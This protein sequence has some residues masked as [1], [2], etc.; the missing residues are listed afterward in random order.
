MFLNCNKCNSKNLFIEIQ[1]NRR[2]L[3][4]GNCGKWQNWITKE[5]LQFA[6]FNN[7]KIINKEI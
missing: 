2:G 1:G 3:Y 5:E 4:C 6:K 7:F